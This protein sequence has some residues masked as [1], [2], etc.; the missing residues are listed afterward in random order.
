MSIVDELNVAVELTDEL[1]ASIDRA[2][3]DVNHAL[4]VLTPPTDGAGK[5]P[6]MSLLDAKQIL[7]RA[8]ALAQLKAKP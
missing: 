2:A 5:R 4:M 7:E 3:L 1:V 6:W 8:S